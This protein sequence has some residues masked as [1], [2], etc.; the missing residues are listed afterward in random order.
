M[1]G[2]V[3]SRIQ[4]LK[5]RSRDTRHAP[6]GSFIIHRIVLATAG[7]TKKEEVSKLHPL[8]SY[9]VRDPKM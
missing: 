2:G 3:N 7:L 9:G 4:N 6:F 1:E 8:K 5:S